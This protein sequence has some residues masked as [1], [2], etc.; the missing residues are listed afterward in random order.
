MG[1]GIKHLSTNSFGIYITHMIWIN[2][3]YKVI[4]Y[5]LVEHNLIVIIPITLI[6]L[7]LSDIT[8]IVCKKIPFVG[9]YI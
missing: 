5:N 4:R 2:V 8:T 3:L 9:K 7:V 6:I 1:G